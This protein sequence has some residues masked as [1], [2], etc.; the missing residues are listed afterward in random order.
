MP[1]VT[2][3]R[4]VGPGRVADPY[5]GEGARVNGWRFNSIGR[6]CVYAAST[7]SLAL[8]EVL[9]HVGAFSRLRG[10]LAVPAT[11]DEGDV[12]TLDVSTLPAGWDARP[13][14]SASQSVGDAWLDSGRSLGLLVPSVVVPVDWNVLLSP[15]H[16]AFARLA[17]GTPVPLPLDARLLLAPG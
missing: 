7:L 6:P 3:W 12:D 14:T 4:V 15:A 17:I 13:H 11:L 5:S 1:S 2:V 16:P 9:A 10:H 8:L